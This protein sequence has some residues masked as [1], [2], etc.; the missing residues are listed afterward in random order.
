MRPTFPPW[1][2]GCTGLACWKCRASRTTS[3]V[4]S[5]TTVQV[6]E[7]CGATARGLV[8]FERGGWEPLGWNSGWRTWFCI[9]GTPPPLQAIFIPPCPEFTATDQAVCKCPASKAS[10][11]SCYDAAPTGYCYRISIL[12]THHRLNQWGKPQRSVFLH[13]S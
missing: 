4:C 2:A 3:M 9:R 7:G 10:K 11:H 5:G 13:G 8:H 6:A 12:A 1:R